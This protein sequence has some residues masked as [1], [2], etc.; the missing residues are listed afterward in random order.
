MVNLARRNIRTGLPTRLQS[1]EMKITISGSYGTAQTLIAFQAI[2][3]HKSSK[4]LTA[5][6][7]GGGGGGYGGYG[8][9]VI[10]TL[11]KPP[12]YVIIGDAGRNI[13]GITAQGAGNGGLCIDDNAGGGGAGTGIFGAG[14]VLLALAGGGA[15]GCMVNA[16]TYGGNAGLSTG[17]GAGGKGLSNVY[18]GASGGL[19]SGGNGGGSGGAGG[20][21]GSDGANGAITGGGVHTGGGGGAGADGS[22]GG[23]GQQ[24][25]PGYQ[26]GP[27]GKGWI[28]GGHG[29]EAGWGEGAGGG[30][31]GGGGG[32]GGAYASG[33]AGGSYGPSMT[34]TSAG[35]DSDLDR[36]TAGNRSTSVGTAGKVVLVY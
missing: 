19:T 16:P 7:W 27:G 4:P 2:D 28:N 8:A 20:T 32:S 6:L 14:N 9:S 26:A 21:N 29:G 23:G 22:G 24:G 18:P 5:K 13:G 11:P 12:A 36:G 33:G 30:G 1:S 31:Y 3:L 25:N 35:S 10:G 15:G 34:I 17:A